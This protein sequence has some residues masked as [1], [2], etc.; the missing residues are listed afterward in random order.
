MKKGFIS[1][2]TLFVLLVLSLTITFIY[3]QNINNSE[4]IS[5]LY[6][7]KQAQYLAESVINKYLVENYDELEDIILTDH[8][9]YNKINEELNKSTEKYLLE[10]D[11]KISYEGRNYTLKLR[12]IY[13]KEDPRINDSYK[14]SIF[15]IRVGNSKSSSEIWFKV[16]DDADNLKNNG[17]KI[18][19][20][21]KLTY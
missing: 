10:D 4:Y 16:I 5:D 21:T 20:I 18:E 11:L 12:H 3:Q 6:N 15:N 17:K 2:L 8:K 13:R 1:I 7:K 9:K 19:I 14:L